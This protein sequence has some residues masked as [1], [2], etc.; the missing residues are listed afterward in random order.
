M[1]K[2]KKPSGK[3]SLPPTALETLELEEQFLEFTSALAN[4]LVGVQPYMDISTVHLMVMDLMQ[5]GLL[6]S[7]T[8]LK[9]GQEIAQRARISVDV[10]CFGGKH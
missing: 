3:G 2:P 4:L 6:H 5:S 7:S 10:D 9:S 1:K 8:A